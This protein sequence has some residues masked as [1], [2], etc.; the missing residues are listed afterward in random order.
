MR[1]CLKN[2]GDEEWAKEA[3]F[4]SFEPL[5]G[6]RR[7][8]CFC[9][10][11]YCNEDNSKIPN[12]CDNKVTTIKLQSKEF[13]RNKKAVTVKCYECLWKKGQNSGPFNPKCGYGENFT[14]P[15]EET[16]DD[17]DNCYLRMVKKGGLFNSI[18]LQK[19]MK[20]NKIVY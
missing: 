20:V 5:V 4:C 13:N 2:L 3:N 9:D 8:F 11:D 10:T 18:Y 1:R 19:N 17:C 14:I 12:V 6:G 16:R 15:A 7:E